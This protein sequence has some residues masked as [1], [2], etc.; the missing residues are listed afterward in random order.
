M[1]PF[2]QRGVLWET[3]MHIFKSSGLERTR[4]YMT[5]NQEFLDEIITKK[6]YIGMSEEQRIQLSA[7]IQDADSLNDLGRFS[8]RFVLKY[9]LNIKGFSDKTAAE[10]FLKL[11]DISPDLLASNELYYHIHPKLIDPSLKAKYTVSRK[12]AGYM[13]EN[14]LL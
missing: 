12:K 8:S 11:L 6:E 2:E 3:Y 1:A 10:S 5:E 13:D 9:C 4:Q 14:H 7:A